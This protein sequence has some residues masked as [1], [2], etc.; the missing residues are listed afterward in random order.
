V[1]VTIQYWGIMSPIRRTYACADRLPGDVAPQ[2]TSQAVTPAG[3]PDRRTECVVAPQAEACCGAATPPRLPCG[4]RCGVIPACPRKVPFQASQ[5]LHAS[6]PAVMDLQSTGGR[7]E[8][9]T[10]C[11]G[12]DT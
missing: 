10:S 11:G 2:L 7:G 1:I 8:R 5:W 9:Q 3:T 4:S 12:E 6:L